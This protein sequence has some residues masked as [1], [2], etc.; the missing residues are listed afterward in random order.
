MVAGFVRDPLPTVEPVAA[1][2]PVES[3]VPPVA[4]PE[5]VAAPVKA[6]EPSYSGPVRVMPDVKKSAPVAP[7]PDVQKSAPVAPASYMTVDSARQVANTV[8]GLGN[9]ARFSRANH[10]Y[11]ISADSVD[12]W[13]GYAQAMDGDQIKRGAVDPTPTEPALSPREA[14]RRW[15]PDWIG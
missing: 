11:G 8:W 2:D 13:L 7:V 12:T 14:R 6:P 15:G 4:V 5:P 3:P 1:S 10:F 9:G